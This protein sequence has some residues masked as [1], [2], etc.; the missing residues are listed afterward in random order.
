MR[1][2]LLGSNGYIGSKFYTNYQNDFNIFPIDLCLFNGDITNS[3]KQNFSRLNSEFINTFDV[4]L[5][6]AGHSSVQMCEYSP[7]RSWVNN[8][9][10]FQSLCESLGNTKL[11]YASS[12][13]VYGSGSSMSSEDSPINFSP[14][15]HYDLQKTTID[16]IA[17]K[18]IK[19]GKNIV[20]MRFGTVN[21]ASPNT[22]SE[23]MI[24]SMVKTAIETGK[25]QAKNLHIR[26]AIL[27]INDLMKALTI[28]IKSDILSGQYNLSSFN[29]T[30]EDIS[31]AVAKL[32]NA[33]LIVNK[34]DPVAYD[35]EMTTKKFEDE[36]G[37]E[38]KDTI[39][40]LVQELKDNY[41]EINFSTRTENDR[42]FE[43]YM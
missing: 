17:N 36:T 35:F 42:D 40:S 43:R 5:C 18:Y 9:N 41:D 3:H 12:A 23:L 27:G 15:C 20:G 14:L 32:C 26:R 22:R 33:E 29:S 1:I 37:F 38:F 6:L 4:V 31:S 25:V 19:E 11:I 39:E 2:L 13:S 7:E 10:Y 34:S 28:P 16:L 8:V 24:N 21:G 30:V